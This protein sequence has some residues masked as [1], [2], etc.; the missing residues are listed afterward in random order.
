MTPPACGP[1]PAEPAADRAAEASPPGPL[2]VLAQIGDLDVRLDQITHHVAHLPEREI[3]AGIE[4]AMRALAGE[5][6]V[7]DTQI[8]DLERRQRGRE[9]EV[10]RIEAKRAHNSERLYESHLTSPK[11]AEAL[12]AEAASLARRQTEIEDH[13]LELME[14]L[15]PLNDT[16]AGLAARQAEARERMDAVDGAIAAAEHQ[17]SSERSEVSSAREALV[18]SA[19]PSLVALYEE[20]RTAARGAPVLGRLVGTTCSA[21]HLEVPS[22]DYER[23]VHLGPD[24]L[25]ECPQCGALLVR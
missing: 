9:D 13:I 1:G 12:T 7:L 8:A 21:C 15:E 6:R 2:E 3:R 14:E 22:V 23:I 5:A 20:R 18:A 4:K 11:E 19:D 24:E 16:R 17:A 10:A 25:A